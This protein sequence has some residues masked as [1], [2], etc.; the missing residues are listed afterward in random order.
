MPFCS[1]R[2]AGFAAYDA[3]HEAPG[4]VCSVAVRLSLSASPRR[5]QSAGDDASV[6][7]RSRRSDAKTFVVL[8]LGEVSPGISVMCRGQPLR[9]GNACAHRAASLAPFASIQR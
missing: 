3:L 1:P 7:G 9:L 8:R 5:V 2:A 4:V 6:T